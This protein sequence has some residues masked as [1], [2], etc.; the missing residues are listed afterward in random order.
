[1]CF[2]LKEPLLF[3]IFFEQGKFLLEELLLSRTL[4]LSQ[5]ILYGNRSFF[6]PCGPNAHLYWHVFSGGTSEDPVYSALGYCWD[7]TRAID[8]VS[9]V[10][11][12]AK[13]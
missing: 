10:C 4:A 13:F 11:V 8:A 7:D 5:N 6:G 2:W 9:G 1:M 12:L 3:L